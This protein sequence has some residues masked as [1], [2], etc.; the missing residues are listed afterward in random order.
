L[1][2]LTVEVTW[3]GG[4]PEVVQPLQTRPD[5]EL[6]E[7]DVVNFGTGDYEGPVKL[8]LNWR[9]SRMVAFDGWQRGD[10]NSCP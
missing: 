5:G 6:V 4:Q 1:V 7:I 8:C 3:K 10:R 9:V 2:C